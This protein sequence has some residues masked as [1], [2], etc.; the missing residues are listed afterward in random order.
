MDATHGLSTVWALSQYWVLRPTITF[1]LTPHYVNRKAP[2]LT[3]F[4]GCVQFLPYFSTALRF[5]GNTGKCTN[6]LIT[7]NQKT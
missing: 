1:S 6:C 2:L 3:K 7:H 4:C 5:T